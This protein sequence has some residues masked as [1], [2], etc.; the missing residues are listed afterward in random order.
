MRVY[1]VIQCYVSINTMDCCL[2]HD[3]LCSPVFASCRKNQRTVAGKQVERERSRDIQ[4]ESKGAGRG[5]GPAATSRPPCRGVGKPCLDSGQSCPL[6]KQNRESL[7]G[8]KNTGARCRHI[9]A[10]KAESAYHDRDRSAQKDIVPA[11]KRASF[12][13]F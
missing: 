6:S 2:V 10:K 5:L 12:S 3:L 9:F 11:E 7:Q 8:S 4:R 13:L 1:Y